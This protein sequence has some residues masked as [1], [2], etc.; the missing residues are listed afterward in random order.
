MADLRG[1]AFSGL[2]WN[3]VSQAVQQ[4]ARFV[5]AIILA[6]LLAPEQFGLIGM[7]Y[8]FTGFAAV[9]GDLGLGAAL[10][11]RREIDDGHLTSVFWTSIVAGAALTGAFVAGAPLVAAFYNEPALRPLTTAIAFEFVLVSVG[12]VHRALMSRRMDFRSLSVVE[13]GAAVLS[14][15]LGIT[16]ALMGFG[17]WSLVAQSLSAAAISAIWISALSPWR[18]RF[19]LSR[20][21]LEEL[22]GFSSNLLGY[23]VLN[24]WV[25]N[26]DDLLIGRVV[27]S[28]ALGVYTRA[29]GL[30]LLPL[31]QISHVV[32]RV[33]FPALSSI[34]GEPGRVKE[35]YLRA[36]SA[37]ALITFPMMVGLFVVADEFVLALL[38]TKWAEL[39]PV[40]R[41]FCVL[42]LIQSISATVGWIYQSQGRTDLM[43]KW[44]MA[45]GAVVMLAFAI[46]IRWGMIGVAIAYVIAS[47][48]VLLYHSFAIPGRLIGLRFSEVVRA[49]APT[50]LRVG[51]MGV[52]IA[53]VDILVPN[54]WPDWAA[55]LLETGTGAIVYLA[56]VHIAAPPAYNDVRE[57]LLGRRR[58]PVEVR[59]ARFASSGASSS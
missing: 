8:I 3:A 55:L 26:F 4:G 17:V 6:R 46:G 5:I 52:L 53:A 1:Q 49:L 29:Y 7:I 18:P 48:G 56:I 58:Q 21:S 15:A 33:M 32:G 34:Q 25:R 23:S 43:F 35:I 13:T 38:G 12:V 42:G 19:S 22:L 41:I 27:G 24:Y 59:E 11:Q 30:M 39:I 40:L 45:A 14:G 28:A 20:T 37:I 44:G 10:V 31:T 57:L 50:M 36:V 51:V 54:S 2:R 16:M 47:G 9:L